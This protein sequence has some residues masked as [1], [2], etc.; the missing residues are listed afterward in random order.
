MV[1]D[2]LQMHCFERYHLVCTSTLTKKNG[3]E[4]EVG[5]QQCGCGRIEWKW[6]MRQR[7]DIY[8]KMQ[9]IIFSS[10]IFYWANVSLSINILF[11]SFHSP[12]RCFLSFFLCLCYSLSLIGT[13]YSQSYL[14]VLRQCEANSYSQT[15]LL[16]RSISRLKLHRRSKKGF[17]FYLRSSNNAKKKQC[18]WIFMK[19]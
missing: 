11:A 16:C 12:L 19:T 10:L 2:P 3:E 7:R 5:R 17:V 15:S 6:T 1:N 9:L 8:V 4:E 18:R 13:V 14:C